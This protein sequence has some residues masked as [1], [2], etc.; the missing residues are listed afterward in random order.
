MRKKDIVDKF[1]NAG[2]IGKKNRCIIECLVYMADKN[3]YINISYRGING[4]VGKSLDTIRV[5]VNKL[6]EANC[7]EKKSKGF[8]RLILEDK[9]DEIMTEQEK[10][11]AVNSIWKNVGDDNMNEEK[12]KRILVCLLDNADSN[13]V[14]ALSCMDISKIVCI[15]LSSVKRF[16]YILG[17]VHVERIG[18]GV[19]RLREY[20][21]SK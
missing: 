19:Y 3:G 5:T 2:N 18:H 14:I 13:G 7:I 10:K 21:K 9:E 4:K 12:Y 16:M 6:L 15:S 1:I 17:G 8:Y 11:I 20:P